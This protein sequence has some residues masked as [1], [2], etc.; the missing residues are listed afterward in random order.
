MKL[1]TKKLM[2]YKPKLNFQEQSKRLTHHYT[3]LISPLLDEDVADPKM[4]DLLITEYTDTLRYSLEILKDDYDVEITSGGFMSVLLQHPFFQSRWLSPL[5]CR[6]YEDSPLALVDLFIGAIQHGV[7][8]KWYG[9]L[10]VVKYVEIELQYHKFSTT[11]ELK[12]FIEK[13]LL[14]N[15]QRLGVTNGL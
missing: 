10:N 2:E 1:K 5:Y 3:S 9:E 6:D 13:E 8:P 15:P 12:T 7:R 4:K 11:E 14:P